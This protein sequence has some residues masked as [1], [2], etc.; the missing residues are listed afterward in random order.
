MSD[1]DTGIEAAL[2]TVFADKLSHQRFCLKHRLDNLGRHGR[3]IREI[4]KNMV[5]ASTAES[6]TAIRE[7]AQFQNL[8]DGGHA[9]INNYDDA[10]QFLSACAA[11]GGKSYRRSS[12]QAVESQNHHIGGART[13][14]LLSSILWITEFEARRY[15]EWAEKSMAETSYALPSIRER[16][17]DLLMLRKLDHWEWQPSASR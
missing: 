15:R 16:M 3:G 12:S 4:Y 9:A 17:A 5:L 2:A 7:S 1:R 11:A 10:V 13:Q 14:D 8:T 6:V